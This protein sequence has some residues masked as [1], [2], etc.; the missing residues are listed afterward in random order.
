MGIVE[1][2]QNRLRQLE[3]EVRALTALA[4]YGSTPQKYNACKRLEEIAHPERLADKINNYKKRPYRNYW[5]DI[6]EK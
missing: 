6:T 1:V 4:A 3:I 5:G 2:E